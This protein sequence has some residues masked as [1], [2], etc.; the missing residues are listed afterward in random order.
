MGLAAD[1]TASYRCFCQDDV[2]YS[3]LEYASPWPEPRG[4]PLPRLSTVWRLTYATVVDVRFATATSSCPPTWPV[5]PAAWPPVRRSCR[6]GR[7][8][9]L[10]ACDTVQ[11]FPLC[12]CLDLGCL[13]RCFGR[14]FGRCLGRCFGRC[15]G[16]CFGRRLLWSKS[17]GSTGLFEVI[18][19]DL[20]LMPLG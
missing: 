9:R 14:R 11:L 3:M 19:A 5:L 4:R 8:R 20:G 1:P 16:M 7:Q 15:F 10:R 6:S 13:G 12:M 18:V 17:V 2:M